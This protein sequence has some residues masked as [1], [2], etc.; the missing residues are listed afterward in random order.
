MKDNLQNKLSNYEKELVNESLLFTIRELA[1]IADNIE[2]V[3]DVAANLL[4]LKI[5]VLNNIIAKIGKTIKKE[6]L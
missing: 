5:K 4:R 1:K 3:Q 2:S 6:S